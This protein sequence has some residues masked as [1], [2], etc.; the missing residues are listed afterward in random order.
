M[1]TLKSIGYVF[2]LILLLTIAIGLV[3]PLTV[4][5]VPKTSTNLT[6]PFTAEQ[7]TGEEVT[8]KTKYPAL[9]ATAGS[10]YEFEIEVSYAGGEKP[11]VFDLRATV[12][13]GFT[14]QITRSY[15]SGANI[16]AVQLDPSTSYP[17]ALKVIVAP[18]FWLSPMPG[19]YKVTVEAA[20]GTIKGSIELK[21]IVTAKI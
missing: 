2:C 21:A 12:P 16:A 4:H 11:R 14:H 7:A 8:F 9:S 6:N 19:E 1:K 5:A 3:T 10:S 17:E 15:G 13:S 20:S 18:Y